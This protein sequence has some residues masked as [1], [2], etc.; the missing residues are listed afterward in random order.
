MKIASAAAT[1]RPEMIQKRMMTVVSGQPTSSKWW[2]TGDMRKRRRVRP[3]ALNTP[4]CSATLP[5]SITF[6]AQMSGRSMWVFVVTARRPSAPPMPSAP[7]SPMKIL[8]GAAFHHR[9]PPHAPA[10][11]AENTARSSGFTSL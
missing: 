10:I 8:A 1:Q 6:R 9:N 4:I 5:A 11:A 2:C 7:T 3:D